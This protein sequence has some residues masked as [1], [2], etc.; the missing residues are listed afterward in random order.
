MATDEKKPS[1]TINTDDYLRS[2]NAHAMALTPNNRILLSHESRV[3]RNRQFKN[4]P[5][6]Y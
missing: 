4:M 5:T 6:H 3:I 2:S 1:Q